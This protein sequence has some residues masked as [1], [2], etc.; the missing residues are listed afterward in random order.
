L[1]SFQHLLYPL[2]EKL[3]LSG[4][5]YDYGIQRVVQDSVFLHYN[6]N[7]KPWLE[8]GIPDYK[9][10]W[11]RFVARDEQFMDECNVSP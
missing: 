5:G 11:K 1:L 4:L 9:K 6:G 10:Y 8:L 3:A 2:D 7:M